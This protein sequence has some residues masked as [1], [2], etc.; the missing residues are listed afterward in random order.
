MAA[1][2]E[3]VAGSR[4]VRQWAAAVVWLV[5]IGLLMAA[6]RPAGSAPSLAAVGADFITT[7]AAG[8]APRPW[9][10]SGSAGLD[11]LAHCAACHARDD[12]AGSGQLA[13]ASTPSRVAGRYLPA[14][15][16]DDAR[17]RAGAVVF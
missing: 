17:V 2:S 10:R 12:A 6:W 4:P 14:L 5:A 11:S 3:G 13:L 16:R 8:G 1:M 15:S 9:L 7:A